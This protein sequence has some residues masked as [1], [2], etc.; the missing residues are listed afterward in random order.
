MSS[1]PVSSELRVGANNVS[2]E[3]WQSEGKLDPKQQQEVTE[4]KTRDQLVRQHEAAHLAAA[5]Q[6]ATGVTYRYVTGP[7]GNRYAVA[8]EVGIDTS[9]IAGNPEATIAKAQ[10][11]RRAAMAPAD[12]SGQD[13]AI[14][15]AASQMEAEARQ[16]ITER[17][18][19]ELQAYSKTGKKVN[20]EQ[21]SASISTSA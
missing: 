4:L 14:A 18:H 17:Q 5:G 19:T 6:Y 8:G 2:I 16:Q 12:P 21:K 3:R 1:L 15:A 9:K 11:L 13:Q 7:D 20:P 10:T